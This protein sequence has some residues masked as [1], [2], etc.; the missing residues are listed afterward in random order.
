MAEAEF[1][2]TEGEGVVRLEEEHLPATEEICI[3]V[4]YTTREAD[5][6]DSVIQPLLQ[7]KHQD[8]RDENHRADTQMATDGT[9]PKTSVPQELELAG[10]DEPGC[11]GSVRSLCSDSS[12]HECPICSELFDSHGEHRVVLLNCNHALCYH[13]AAGI[14]RRAK[15]LGRLCCPFCRQ[16]TPFLQWEIRRLQEQSYTVY[17][18]LPAFLISPDPEPQAVP[19]PPRRLQ[20]HGCCPTCLVRGLRTR[21]FCICCSIISFLLLLLAVLA[22]ALHPLLILLWMALQ[23]HP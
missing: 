2:E 20:A 17:E 8:I 19:S 21:R 18:P 22:Y 7:H 11:T 1:V 4:L 15:D 12:R 23:Y 5:E 9:D 16:T 3:R 14:M 13:C 6:R 10:R